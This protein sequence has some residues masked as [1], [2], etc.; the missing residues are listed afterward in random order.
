MIN[1]KKKFNPNDPKLI[2]VLSETL[3]KACSELKFDIQCLDWFSYN[4]DYHIGKK[5]GKD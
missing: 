3:M 1:M 4:P 5:N 2:K